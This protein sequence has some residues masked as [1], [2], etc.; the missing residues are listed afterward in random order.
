MKR[1]VSGRFPWVFTGTMPSTFT[2]ASRQIEFVDHSCSIQPVSL[3]KVWVC[4]SIPKRTLPNIF[5]S[6]ASR[7]PGG[8]TL[9]R[10]L[11]LITC[12]G[13]R[14]STCLIVFSRRLLTSPPRSPSI[15][16]PLNLTGA[17]AQPTPNDRGDPRGRGRGGVLPGTPLR[18]GRGRSGAGRG[19][20]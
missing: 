6:C 20:R 15:G 8:G 17:A 16:P 4:R 12:L 1:I 9:T 3:R 19:E 10:T 2:T 13:I 18:T 7:C 14:V 11:E 5:V